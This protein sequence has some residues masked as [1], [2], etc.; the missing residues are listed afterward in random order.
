ML[1]QLIGSLDGLLSGR[2]FS[3]DDYG[4]YI[5][6]L[7]YGRA[8]CCFI[9][10]YYSPGDADAVRSMTELDEILN[11]NLLLSGALFNT[12]YGS[13]GPLTYEHAHMYSETLRK[14]KNIFDPRGIMN[15]GRLCF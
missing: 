14:V 9:H 6:P 4:V 2:G 10:L 11:R 7:E 13:Q 5:Q 12:P 15:P 1:P 8:Y 3:T